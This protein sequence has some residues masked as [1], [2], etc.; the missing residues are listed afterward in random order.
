MKGISRFVMAAALLLGCSGLAIAQCAGIK[1]PG[2]FDLLQTVTGSQDNLSSIGL[3]TVTFTGTPLKG[4]V[5]TSDTIVCR[6]TPLPNP[7]PA[8]GATLNIQIVALFLQG[9]STWN[10]MPV[11]VYATINQTNGAVPTTQLPQPDMLPIASTGTMTVFP[12]GTFNTNQLN[13]QADLI[14]VPQG[15]P[16]TATP[17][18]TTPM[19][20]DKISSSGSTWTTTPP[21]GYPNSTTFPAGGFFVNQPPGGTLAAAAF[22]TGPVVRGSL[23]G[24]G[25]VLLGITLLKI[26]SGVKVGKVTLRPVYMTG[27]A[28]IA[29]FA[30]WKAGKMVFP[31]IVHAQ[32]V[33]CAPH[34][35]A[36]FVKEG[37]VVVVHKIVTS[38]CTTTNPAAAAAKPLH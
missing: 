4:Q 38:V 34:T 19:P 6:I 16:V 14:V 21:S 15:Q 27:V 2:G 12:N 17:I 36:V 1:N 22:V 28:A 8:G 30:A 23:Y 37:G 33:V 26:W 13:I 9:N 10:G 35:Q 7:V 18:F 20:A 24:L 25:L 5:G 29:W 11:T 3:G 31:K 32:T